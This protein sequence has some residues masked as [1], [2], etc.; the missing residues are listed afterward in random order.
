MK[1]LSLFIVAILF[2]VACS[3]DNQETNVNDAGTVNASTKREGVDLERMYADMINSPSYL[4]LVI[5]YHITQ[6]KTYY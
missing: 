1:K 2:A 4:S 3:T 6:T 5:I